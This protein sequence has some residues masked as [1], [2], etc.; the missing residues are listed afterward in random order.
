MSDQQQTQDTCPKCGSPL[1]EIIQTRTGKQLRRCSAGSWNAETKQVDGC[2]YTK[3]IEPE[4]EKLEEACP[5]CG[6]PLLMVTIK[7]KKAKKCSTNKWDAA[8]RKATGCDYIQWMGSTTEP[9]E[10]DCPLCGAKLVLMTTSTGKK[11][12]KCSTSG[13]DRKNKRAT[14]CEFTEWQND[15]PKGKAARANE[16]DFND[17]DIPF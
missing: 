15:A 9:L 2:D 3:W 12:K 7:G 10:E 5:K 17:D 13:W 4:P 1:S 14:G 6:A 16:D 8:A 11:L